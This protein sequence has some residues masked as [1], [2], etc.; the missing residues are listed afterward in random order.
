MAGMKTILDSDY[1]V[2]IPAGEVIIGLSDSQREKIVTRLRE[3]VIDSSPKIDSQLLD[4][5][6]DK[7]CQYP[8]VHLSKEER[9]LFRETFD[10]RDKIVIIEETLSSVPP[11]KTLSLPEFYIFRFP[12][13]RF[14]YHL[15]THGSS[16]MEIPG[17]LEEPEKKQIETQGQKMEISGRTVAAVQ[18]DEALQLCQEIGARLPSSFEW[19]KAA[20]GTDDRLY[21]W[22]ND[23]DTEAGFFY[24]GQSSENSASRGGRIVD[25]FPK[26]VS[27]YEVWSMAGGLPELVKVESKRPVMTHVVKFNGKETFI[28]IKGCHAKESN[29]AF[30]WF[31][32]I[33]ALPGQGFWVSLRPVLDTWPHSKWSGF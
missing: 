9:N 1:W 21:P 4:Q 24:Y 11:Q 8:R 30:A 19:E 18:L 15:Y 33:L 3:M 29:E 7:L 31:D 26:G 12:V 20:R 10:P 13:T 32:H 27:P 5:A 16:A 22:G 6:I 28:D 14:Q 17:A 23:W 2:K 25:A